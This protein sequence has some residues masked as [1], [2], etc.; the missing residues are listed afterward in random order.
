[1]T[2]QADRQIMDWPK[3]I[4]EL[5]DHLGLD[6]FDIAGHSGGGPYAAAC[7]YALP[8]R[9]LAAAS[10][11]GAGPID[12]TGA[13][14]RMNG[15]NRFGFRVGQYIPWPIWHLFV[16]AFYRNG[17][18][19]PKIVME[20]DSDT[21]PRPDAELWKIDSIREVCYASVV[22]ALRNG[23]K[24]YAWDARLLSRPWN[25]P[26]EEIRVPFH[27]WHGTLDRTT[28]IQMARYVAGR[29]PNSKL[30]VCE[31]EAHL[32]IFPHWGEILSTLLE[33]G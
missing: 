18:R 27:L 9:V 17:H 29:I 11:S 5:A 12:S 31:D 2:F 26:L 20:R 25:I 13:V 22:E 24:G 32:L 16:W 8:E 21:R 33:H 14:Q 30:H 23:T 7:A 28:P 1:S 3:D 19:R 15:L 10:I 6:K 4:A